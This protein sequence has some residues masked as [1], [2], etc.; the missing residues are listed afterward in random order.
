[1]EIVRTKKVK[2]E[3]VNLVRDGRLWLVKVGNVVYYRSA[4]ELFAVERF[5]GI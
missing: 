1:M 5:L 2:N 4:R 3:V